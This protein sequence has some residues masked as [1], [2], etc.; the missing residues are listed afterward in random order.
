MYSNFNAETYSSQFQMQKP[1]KRSETEQTDVSQYQTP[2]DFINGGRADFLNSSNPRGH[3][4]FRQFNTSMQP[5]TPINALAES[6]P[7]RAEEH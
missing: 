1:M 3:Q 6:L 7:N 4:D 5:L 2:F